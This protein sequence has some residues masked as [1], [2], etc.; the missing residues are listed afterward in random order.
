LSILSAF[1]LTAAGAVPPAPPAPDPG[2]PPAI[3]VSRQLLASEH[4]A[5]GDVIALAGDPKGSH[6]RPFRIAGVYEPV[7]D[8]ARLGAPALEARLHLPD[9]MALTSDPADPVSSE[10]VRSVNVKLVDPREA[11]A[12]TRELSARVPGLL[13]RDRAR[14]DDDADVTFVVLDRFH[15]A[16]SLVTVIASSIFLLALMVMLVDE[17]RDTVAI[18]RLIGLRR[19]R[20]FIQVLAEG[21][22]IALAGALFGVLLAAGLEGG[23]NRFFQWR[24]D[25]ALV[26]VRVT[27]AIAA[28]AVSVAVP[29]GILASVAASWSLLRRGAMALARR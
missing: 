6:P 14:R 12:F 5:V 22:V 4:L 18:L 23:F 27:P 26:F 16:I 25:T 17:R 9:L 15:L 29:L 2:S 1:F 28:R 7:P 11:A 13:V 20:I 10:S 8:P 3:L 19:R 21:L 24:Y